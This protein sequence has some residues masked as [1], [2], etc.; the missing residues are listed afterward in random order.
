M[1]GFVEDKKDGEPEWFDA[2]YE[3]LPFL[4]FSCGIIGHGGMSCDKPA[5]RNDQGKLPYERDPPLRAPDDW[6]RKLQ[7]FVEA[8]AESYGSGTSSCGKP[9]HT[10]SG[11]SGAGRG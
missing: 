7:S 1:R 6:R 8:A 3:K 5:R 11:R 2:Q 9:N 10:T 4:C